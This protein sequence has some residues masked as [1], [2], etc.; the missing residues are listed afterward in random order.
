MRNEDSP[1]QFL[2]SSLIRSEPN[3][4][5]DKVTHEL[6]VL[7]QLPLGLARLGLQGVLGGLVTLLQSNTNFVPWCHYF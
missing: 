4:L 1:E 5:S 6:I 3:D 7:C 2:G